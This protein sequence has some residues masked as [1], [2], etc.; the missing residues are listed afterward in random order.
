MT[1]LPTALVPKTLPTIAV[2]L[3]RY[4]L[5]NSPSLINLLEFLS[6]HFLVHLYLERMSLVDIP[7]LQSPRFRIS[8]IQRCHVLNR[9]ANTFG[10]SPERYLAVDPHGLV[11]CKR[12][13]PKARPFYYSLELYLRDDHF[14]L[15]YPPRVMRK[16][17]A[18]IR[19]I[20]GLL[21]QSEEKQQL[22][23][24]DYGCRADLPV[25]LLP[26]TGSG[27]ADATRS[28]LLRQ[29]LG[30]PNDHRIALHLGGI[31]EWFSCID[32]ARLFGS[33][34]GWTLFFQGYADPEYLTHLEAVI[35]DEKLTNV[36][37][38]Q[39]TYPSITAVTPI[40]QSCDIGIAWYNDIS[41]G[42]RTAGLSSGKIVSYLQRGL[43]VIAK[44]YA[45]TLRGIQDPQCGECVDSLSEI[46]SALAKIMAGWDDYSQ[47]ASQEYEQRY[48]FENYEIGLLSFLDH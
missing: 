14:G 32:L 3:S 27:A 21:I 37:I 2:F 10:V 30:V 12:L 43:P 38:S 33:I 36:Y 19:D 15:H 11:L 22:F 13:F 34:A 48:R 47:R 31:A 35:R 9:I 20:A 17:R 23:M 46:P 16:E 4:S 29:S 5:G 40:V 6:R 39:H 26:V 41:A 28:C 7:L 18:Y 44:R 25:F 42:F 8:R 45:S 1:D 24:A